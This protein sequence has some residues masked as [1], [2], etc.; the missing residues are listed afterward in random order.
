MSNVFPFPRRDTLPI[1]PPALSGPEHEWTKELLEWLLHE[2]FGGDV[3]R[4]EA[5]LERWCASIGEPVPPRP[6]LD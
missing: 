1:V 6:L 5:G 2:H 3:A 4:L